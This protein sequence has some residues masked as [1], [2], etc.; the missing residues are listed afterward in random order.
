[1]PVG[2]FRGGILEIPI[3]GVSS[4][5]GQIGGGFSP[6]CGQFGSTG[7]RL[8][9]GESPRP[10][11]S[12]YTLPRGFIFPSTEVAHAPRTMYPCYN[13]PRCLLSLTQWK[14]G[15]PFGV[16]PS[17]H[18]KKK[19]KKKGGT[20]FSNRGVYMKL[21]HRH[22][23]ERRKIAPTSSLSALLHRRSR[24][25]KISQG[26]TSPLTRFLRLFQE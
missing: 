8:S 11:I 22:E 12:L 6:L 17:L 14:L 26:W 21:R 24:P 5:G 16:L 1:M 7:M 4:R 2:S 15:A 13:R 9:S 25:C 19:K 23:A 3:E 10:A 20:S 18:S